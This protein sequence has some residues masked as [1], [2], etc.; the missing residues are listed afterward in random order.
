MTTCFMIQPFDGGKFDK[1]FDAVLKPA[2]VAAGLEPYRV[3][4]DPGASIP[5]D[6]IEAGIRQAAVCVADITSDNPNVWFELGYA[7][8]VGKDICLICHEDRTKYPF[9]VQHR[10]II[11]YTAEAPQDFVAL[12]EKITARLQAMLEK[13][14]ASATI[15]QL[16]KEEA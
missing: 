9:D 16:S 2:V 4:R 11:R 15:P 6:Q 8:A 3:D 14:Q 5:I 13:Q 1:R 7:I 12:T 10:N